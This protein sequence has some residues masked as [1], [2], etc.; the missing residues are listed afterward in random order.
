MTTVVAIPAGRVVDENGLWTLPW[1]QWAI[2]VQQ[3]LG[4]QSSGPVSGPVGSTSGNLAKWGNNFGSLLA[5][6]GYPV[7]ASGHALAALDGTNVWTHV[8]SAPGWAVADSGTTGL[9]S[10]GS[11][12]ATLQLSGVVKATWNAGGM[13]LAQG[14]SVGA[15]IVPTSDNT[16]SCGALAQRWTAVFAV[17]GTIQT[18]DIRTKRKVRPLAHPLRSA[19]RIGVI[20]YENDFGESLGVSAQQVRTVFPYLV[21]GHDGEGGMLGLRESALGVVALAAL[22]SHVRAMRWALAVTWL[23]LAWALLR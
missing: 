15:A 21:Y 20:R 18:S 11:G 8:Q 9:F 10:P 22:Q 6:S 12:Q 2:N 4:I 16:V 19:M 13:V 7:G 1:R 14:L 17:N 5:D 23:L 3:A